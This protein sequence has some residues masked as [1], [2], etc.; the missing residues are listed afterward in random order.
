MKIT[1]ITKH[2]GL[3]KQTTLHSSFS[4]K[5]L[6]SQCDLQSLCVSISMTLSGQLFRYSRAASQQTTE[7]L[8]PWFPWH[9]LVDHSKCDSIQ[10]S[11]LFL[12]AVQTVAVLDIHSN[13]SS[14]AGFLLQFFWGQF[15][16]CPQAYAY[17]KVEHFSGRHGILSSNIRF[18]FSTKTGHIYVHLMGI[19]S[20]YW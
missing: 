1:R 19:L 5:C 11:G 18:L 7:L 14:K 3:T 15:L 4:C 8:C 17:H 16:V 9:N 12:H 13:L 6:H 20:H 10:S 2:R